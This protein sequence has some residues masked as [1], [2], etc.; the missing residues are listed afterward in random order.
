MC[1][2]YGVVSMRH[3]ALHIPHSPASEQYDLI[4]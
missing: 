1:E 3:I 2:W 4:Y